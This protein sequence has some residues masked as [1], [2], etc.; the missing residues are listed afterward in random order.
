MRL[1]LAL[2]IGVFGLTY[3]PASGHSGP[4]YVRPMTLAI[5]VG[6]AALAMLQLT[7]ANRSSRRLA[8]LSFVADAVAVLGTIGLYSFDP[9]RYLLALVV[10]VQAEGGVVLGLTGGLIAW[11]GISIGYLGLEFAASHVSNAPVQPVELAIRIGAGLLLGLGGGL[12]SDELSGERQQRLAERESELRHLQEAEARYRSLV[13]Q[14]PVITYID[15]VDRT[16]S[17]IFISPQVEEVVGYRP[18]EWISDPTLWT[19]LLHPEDRGRVLAQNER[20]NLTGDPF[21]AE[22]RL[23]ARDGR[24]VW[25]R[26]EAILMR[27]ERGRAQYWQGVMVDITERKVAEEEV[28]FL[29]YHD[30]LTGLPNRLMFERVLDLA[31]ARARRRDLAVAVLYMDLDNFK[32]VNDT[33]GHAVG[34]EVLGQMAHR[35]SSAVRATDVVARQGG[36]EFLVLL[37]DLDRE[38]GGLALGALSLAEAVAERIHHALESPFKLGDQ[39]FR[40]TASIGVS[41]YPISGDDAE[42]LLKQ[43]DDAMYR[44]KRIAP[45]STVFAENVKG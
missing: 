39:E 29:A 22:Y 26:D 12:I 9:R 4:A 17:A 21:K 41:Y 13:E 7:G 35:L 11:A 33:L 45:G 1:G 23:V 40:I 27:D 32:E 15:A 30:K 3:R 37:A 20:T 36:D 19:K 24:V 10:V 44:S 18:Q 25:V 28:T 38:G 6:L 5:A 2:A 43:A 31:L 16:S 14:I 8:F 42:E 34:D